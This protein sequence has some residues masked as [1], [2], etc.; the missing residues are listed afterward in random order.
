MIISVRV[1]LPAKAKSPREATE[2]GIET[3]V[4][5]LLRNAETPMDLIEEGISTEFKLLAL[6]ALL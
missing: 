4:R 6:N 1:L 5:L 3:E 2:V